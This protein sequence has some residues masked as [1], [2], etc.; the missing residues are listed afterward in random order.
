MANYNFEQIVRESATKYIN[1]EVEKQAEQ[2]IQRM[3]KEF[4]D[5]LRE[6]KTQITI[7]VSA[8]IVQDFASMN[9]ELVVRIPFDSIR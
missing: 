4:E 1:D 6:K 8:K 9:N 5:K 7:A 2:E 3:L